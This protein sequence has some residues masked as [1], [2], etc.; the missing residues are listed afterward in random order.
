[1][2]HPFRGRDEGKKGN[3]DDREQ[4]HGAQGNPNRGTLTGMIQ[5]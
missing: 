3:N 4:D 1:M 2:A 5:N